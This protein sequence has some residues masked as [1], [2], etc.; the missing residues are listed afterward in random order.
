MIGLQGADRLQMR[1]NAVKDSP[2]GIL[3]QWQIATVA[4][5]KRAVPR[6]TGHLGR[7]IRAGGLF[8][9]HAIVEA[10]VNYAAFVEYGTRA[11]IIRPRN[12]RILRFAANGGSARLT[13]AVRRGGS[14]VFA[15]EVHHPGTRPHPFLVPGARA[16]LTKVGLTAIVDQWNKAA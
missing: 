5:A 12:K 13:G 1:L 16:A 2:R 4:E 6:K 15:R 14:A 3:R 9:D 7:S 10:S 11:H 8:S